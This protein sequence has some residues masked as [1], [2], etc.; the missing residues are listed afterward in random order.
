MREA[1]ADARCAPSEVDYV[2]AHATATLQGDGE[3]A[4][5]IRSVLGANVP[6]SSLK[7]NLGHTLGAS[8]AIELIAAIEGLRRG[9]LYPTRNL[10]TVAEECKGIR[11]VTAR[12]PTEARIFLKNSF[13]FGGIHA[14]LVCRR[15]TDGGNP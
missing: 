11:H 13:A 14:S 6:V 15:W 2:S 12:E 1:L 8:G 9:H 7:G 4:A 5:A 10:E 3:E